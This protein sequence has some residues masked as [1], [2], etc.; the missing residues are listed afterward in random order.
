[1]TEQPNNLKL[2]SNPAP[3][4]PMTNSTVTMSVLRRH[5]FSQ[6]EM[7]ENQMNKSVFIKQIH[8]P[9]DVILHSEPS[10]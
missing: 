6:S 8:D 4:I 5:V 3:M 10:E 1:M 2:H 7:Q 9:D